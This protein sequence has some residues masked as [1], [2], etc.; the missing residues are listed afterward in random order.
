[1][2]RIE[3]LLLRIGRRL[4]D[5]SRREDHVEEEQKY[6]AFHEAGKDCLQG[7]KELMG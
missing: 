2:M 6:L 3:S 7:W 4:E 5:N 1:M